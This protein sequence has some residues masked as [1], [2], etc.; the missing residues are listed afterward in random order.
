ML[1]SWFMRLT[2]HRPPSDAEIQRELADHLDCDA[3]AMERSGRAAPSAARELARRRFG[4]LGGVGE[5]VHDV[6]HWVWLEQLAQDARHGLRA[7]VRSPAYSIAITITLALGIAAAAVTFSLSDAIRRPFPQLRQDR[8]LWITQRS[9][10]CPACNQTSPAALIALQTRAA[11]LVPFAAATWRTT[12]RTTDGSEIVDG[13]TVSPRSFAALATPFAL[14]HGF[15]ADAGE[16]SASPSAVLSYRFWHDRFA[17]SPSVLDSV[18]T[19]GGAPYTVVGVLAKDVVFPTAT[20]VYAPIVL[21]PAAATNYGSRNFELF[22]ALAPG[23]TFDAARAEVHTVGAQLARESPKTDSGWVLDARPISAY[24]TDDVV[25]LEQISGIA[26][27]LVFLAACMS[28]ANLALSRV[29]TRRNELALRAAL[30]VR[31]W[32][33]ARHLLTEGL[34]VSLAA[35][36]LGLLLARWGVRALRDAIPA[37]FALYLPGWAR[38][39]LN[40][41]TFAFALAAAVVALLVF[42]ALPVFRATRVNLV[43]VLSDGGRARTGGTRGTRT[44]ATLVVL[45][46]SIAIVVLTAATLLA[47]SVRNMVAGDPGVRIDHALVMHLSLPHGMNDS[48]A[49][50]FYRRLDARLHATAGIRAAGVASTTPL[51]NNFA[52]VAFAIPGRAPEPKG[53]PLSAIDQHVTSDYGR[54]SGLRLV[55]GRWLNATDVD[56]AQR[57]VVVNQMLADAMW[58]GIRALGHLVTV[59][60]VDWTVVGVASNVHH[61]GFDE[62]V[63]YTVYRSVDQA[64]ELGGDLAVWTDGDPAA[65]AAVVRQAVSRADPSAAVGG[66]MTMRDMEAR[67]V[68]PFRMMAGMLAVLAV[69]TMTIAVVGLYGL[70]AYGVAQRTREIG[71]RIALGA[72]SRDILWQAGGSAVRLAGLGTVFGIVGAA[73]F[74]RL[75]TVMLYGVTASDPRTFVAVSAGLLIVA[76]AAALGPS[77]RAA[78]V[79]PTIALRG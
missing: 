65:M 67:H 9:A 60:G 2:G 24:H 75:L 16:P 79:D 76:L 44:R 70:I 35:G 51:S 30:G 32:R 25:V 5:S 57:T 1:R 14:G 47:Q 69:V 7:L 56:G 19:L 55:A 74:A 49:R 18:I 59:G 45:E 15:A 64:V 4:N 37:D 41:R 78:R 48:A 38:L 33:L 58:P 27:V 72:S 11:S 20:D 62:P 52:G 50:A 77:W 53:R 42:A 31:R 12:L 68:S 3:A 22:A 28:A 13:F 43:T 63:R 21:T 71:V 39:G 66:V 61:G 54:A 23:A 8:L 29:E 73:A 34:L 26:A 40:A 10:E 17:G 6:W 46:V 36:A